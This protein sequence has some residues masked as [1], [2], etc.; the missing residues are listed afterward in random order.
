MTLLRYKVGKMDGWMEP[1]TRR[2]DLLLYRWFQRF[3]PNVPCRDCVLKGDPSRLQCHSAHFAVTLHAACNFFFSF[4]HFPVVLV[5]P[6]DCPRAAHLCFSFP[7]PTAP[8]LCSPPQI[9]M[10]FTIQHI[11]YCTAVIPR[12][13]P[14]Q[15]LALP[16]VENLSKVQLRTYSSA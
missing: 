16:E 14:C 9:W 3:P 5:H 13:F 12:R 2:E 6:H 1:T 15:W 7:S 10:Y 4:Y 8:P 11:Q